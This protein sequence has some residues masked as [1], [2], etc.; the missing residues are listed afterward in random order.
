LIAELPRK[1]SGVV[2][3]GEVPSHWS[4]NYL[5]NVVDVSGGS[6]PSKENFAFWDGSIP[7]VSPK[8]MKKEVIVD[9]EDHVP[10]V[11]S[12]SNSLAGSCG[13]LRCA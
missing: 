8:D 3:L 1:D 13:A 11:V 6:T 5:G 2:W 7:W 12:T 9:S 4:V 10:S